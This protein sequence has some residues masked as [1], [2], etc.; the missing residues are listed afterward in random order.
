MSSSS[1]EPPLPDHG[2]D[3][4]GM[5]ENRQ[6]SARPP[7]IRFTGKVLTAER[8]G[9]K[10]PAE[11]RQLCAIFSSGMWLVREGHDEHPLV[12]HV[13]EM[14]A[15]R[16]IRLDAPRYVTPDVFQQVV[17]Y[18][19][20]VNP[21]LPFWVTYAVY[22]LMTLTLLGFAGRILWVFDLVGYLKLYLGILA[23]PFVVA[24]VW[25]RQSTMA[26]M[27]MLCLVLNLFGVYM[28]I[29]QSSPLQVTSDMPPGEL[30]LFSLNV[31]GA[32]GSKDEIRA[33]LKQ[34]QPD[35]VY[36]VGA[37]RIWTDLADA[38][39][40]VLP[41]S[42]TVD[43]ATEYGALMLSRYPLEQA[44]IGMAGPGR[45]PLLLAQIET[46][47][48]RVAV[49][50]AHAPAV[51]DNMAAFSR[52]IYL[53][54]ISAMA[55]T[56]HLPT[57]IMGTL[58]APPWSS[59]FDSLRGLP[60]LAPSSLAFPATW[61]KMAGPAGLPLDQIMLTIPYDHPVPVRFA[62]VVRGPSFTDTHH[63]SLIAV[64]RVDP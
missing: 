59:A 3:K 45:L 14:A 39:I 16:G 58:N 41:Y 22:A 8:G 50:G 55:N 35:I 13:A 27:A 63:A 34:N 61:P 48:G 21:R 60:L 32:D 46:P 6:F 17:N 12:L 56:S 28:A 36:L 20:K 1:F 24:G 29:P 53:S 10:V 26:L 47:I 33:W 11:A 49:I 42:R 51:T 52:N 64:A 7:R 44:S 54:Q 2:Q 38:L 18:A 57:F 19:R 5:A 37:G 40:N 30:R 15:D 62:G 25:A 31:S 23:V 4:A 9:L 43:S